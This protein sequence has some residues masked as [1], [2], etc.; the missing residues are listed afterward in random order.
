VKVKHRFE[1]PEV[2]LV[3]KTVKESMQPDYWFIKLCEDSSPSL[4]KIKEK[5]LVFM[6]RLRAESKQNV[7][8]Y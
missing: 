2:N 8:L 7:H 4:H 5:L 6:R 1:D 3:I